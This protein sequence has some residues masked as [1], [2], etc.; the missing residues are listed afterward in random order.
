MESDILLVVATRN[1]ISGLLKI[2]KINSEV[3]SCS[4]K[5]IICADLNNISYDLIIT[6]PSVINTAHALTVAIEKN[7]PKIILQ[8]GIAG[9]FKESKLNIGDIAIASEARY[10]H[11]G[12]ESPSYYATPDMLP[13]DLIDKTPSSKSGVYTLDSNYADKANQILLKSDFSKN[14]SILKGPIITVSTITSTQKT[15]DHIYNTYSPL[16]EAMEGAASAHVA[17]LYDIPFLEIRSGSN[18]VGERDKKKWDI[19][20]AS[21][22]IS[23]ACSAIIENI[24]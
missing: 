19:P 8:A 5:T 1:E 2:S 6:G 10:I 21:K 18:F 22:R 12:V 20:L 14:H 23:R 7:K 17:S 4:N 9:I 13:F 15:T 11:T 3:V 24:L 16:M